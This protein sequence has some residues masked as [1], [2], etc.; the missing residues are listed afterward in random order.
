MYPLHPELPSVIGNEGV[1]RVLEVGTGVT[2]V[3]VGDRV[4]FP[5]G[6]FTW[7]ERMD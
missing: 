1:G 4:T 6:K 2:I 3:R 7:R 5:I